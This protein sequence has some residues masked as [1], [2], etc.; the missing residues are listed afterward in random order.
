VAGVTKAAVKSAKSAV[1]A[2][3]KA[4]R[5]E[6]LVAWTESPASSTMPRVLR[7]LRINE[8]QV[9]DFATIKRAAVG[10]PNVADIAILSGN[11]LLVN[12]KTPGETSLF[13]WD[14]RGQTRYDLTVV[15]D[16]VDAAAVVDRVR[17]DVAH[18]GVAVRAIGDTLFLEGKVNSEPEALRAEAIATAYTRNV[19]NLIVVQTAQ[20][21]E[22]PTRTVQTAMG[23][24]ER[25][26]GDVRVGM[27]AVND[28][29]MVVEGSV[30]PAVAERVRQVTAAL[31]GDVKVLDMLSV[32]RPE[33]QQVVVKCR[34]MEI[35]R[36]RTKDLGINWGRVAFSNDAN[37]TTRAS[38]LDPP[39]LIGRTDLSPTNLLKGG[40]L[41][42]LDPLGLRL[43][44]LV[45]NGGGRVLA[46]PNMCILEGQRGTM[47]VGGEIPI[48]VAQSSG[49]G[50]AI[51]V[52]WKPFGVR[53]AM[54]P[55]TI[56]GDL[57]TLKMAPEVSTLDYSNAIRANGIT[58]PA[59]RSRRCEG[60]VQVRHG[61]TIALGG[62]LMNEDSVATRRTPVLSR[63]PIIGELFKS[64]DF[65]RGETELIMIMTPEVLKPG[66]VMPVPTLN[67]DPRR[68]DFKGKVLTKDPEAEGKKEQPQSTQADPERKKGQPQSTQAE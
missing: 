55:T 46:E 10:N 68:P 67:A 38:V 54:E 18:P 42:M 33:Q 52:E 66:E 7:A 39:F 62:L 5:T 65:Q 16:T 53:M 21:E 56:N 37:G 12:G 24:M 48:P 27:R 25:A 8:S 1:P 60:V 19:K 57:I 11:Q 31:A 13:V 59:V 17:R 15:P 32:G 9:L 63:I 20:V 3:P 35:N 49:N 58:I 36:Q 14:R 26:L 4:A 51:T 34:V 64:R 40:P 23:E 28:R 45:N 47:L 44:A 43:N 41:K 22:A 30:T 6:R 50:T 61:Q 2:R 29:T